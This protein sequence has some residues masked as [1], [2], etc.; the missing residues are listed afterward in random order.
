[1]RTL[2]WLTTFFF[3]NLFTIGLASD[4]VLPTPADPADQTAKPQVADVTLKSKDMK[5]ATVT[6]ADKTEGLN[7]VISAESLSKGRYILKVVE[8]CDF[9]KK[10]KP[11]DSAI[12]IGSFTT[13][14]GNISSEF[15][16]KDLSVGEKH[17]SIANK[18][19]SL[20]KIASN[21]KASRVACAPIAQ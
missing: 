9:K 18:A 7:V 6:L 12:D 5:V 10:L 8:N 17:Q 13:I 3:F 15:V 20:H 11:R 14:S 21:G 16:K 2:I 4:Q 19:I 1:M